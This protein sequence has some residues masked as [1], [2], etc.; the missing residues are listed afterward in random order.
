[1]YLQGGQ[2]EVGIS[3]FFE[4]SIVSCDVFLETYERIFLLKQ[5]CERKFC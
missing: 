5:T 2:T 1:M 4:E 3:S